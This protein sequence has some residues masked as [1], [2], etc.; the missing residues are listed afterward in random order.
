M[1]CCLSNQIFSFC[2]LTDSIDHCFSLG[3][4]VF[5]WVTS[6][7]LLERGSH[8]TARNEV[9]RVSLGCSSMQKDW[10]VPAYRQCLCTRAN[11]KDLY[12]ESLGLEWSP[13]SS[14]LCCKSLLPWPTA[15]AGCSDD[16]R[17]RSCLPCLKW[18]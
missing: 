16:V 14:H 2:L 1:L 17:W 12:T 13:E 11:V 5:D 7:S 8:L 3:L 15:G 9:L 4:A 18:R 10:T 6:E